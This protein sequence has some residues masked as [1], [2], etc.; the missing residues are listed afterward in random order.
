MSALPGV[1]QALER[2]RPR[3][4]FDVTPTYGA[5][6]QVDWRDTYLVDSDYILNHERPASLRWFDGAD[7]A[8]EWNQYQGA[9]QSDPLSVGTQENIRLLGAPAYL[10]V[11]RLPDPEAIDQWDRHPDHGQ[12][13]LTGVDSIASMVPYL[14]LPD[15]GQG[16]DP[17]SMAGFGGRGG[18]PY[19][20]D[21]GKQRSDDAGISPRHVFRSPPAFGDQTAAMYAAGL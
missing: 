10:N 6:W 7:N 11:M 20:F 19:H 4:A 21:V 1:N 14:E 12:A 9:I 18:L 5:Y 16:L 13:Q 3:E 17:A 2:E 15:Y 8:S